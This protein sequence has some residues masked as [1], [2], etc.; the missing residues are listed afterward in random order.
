MRLTGGYGSERVFSD[1][2]ELVAS[3]LELL[4]ERKVVPDALC[5]SRDV[6]SFLQ[7]LLQQLKVRLLE[8]RLG[9]TDGVGRVGDDAVVLILVLWQEL[10]AVSDEDLDSGVGVALSHE[11]E[12]LLRNTDDS[13]VF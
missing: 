13:L 4:D 10:E 9:G 1:G 3:L 2:E 5:L 8:Q 7:S 11:G 6:T 12:E